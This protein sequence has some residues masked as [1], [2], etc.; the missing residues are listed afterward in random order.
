MITLCYCLASLGKLCDTK[1]TASSWLLSGITWQ[2][3]WCKT[4][5]LLCIT[6]WYHLAS[7]V[8]Q[9]RDLPLDYCLAS[10]GKLCDAKQRLSSGLLSGIT[11]EAHWCKTESLLCITVWN[12]LVSFV[13][14]NRLSSRLLSGIT[15]QALWCKIESL[16]CIIVWHNLVSFV[17]Q[18]RISSR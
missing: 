4:E 14:Q 1:Q 9:N 5:S 8:M 13:M 17:M 6:I 18:N 11:W 15:W 2:A 7:F 3:L 12:H 10:L 16:L